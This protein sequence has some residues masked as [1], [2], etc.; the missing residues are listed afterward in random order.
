LQQSIRLIGCEQ[1]SDL[2]SYVRDRE[3]AAVLAENTNRMG[4]EA[5]ALISASWAG[6]P[7]PAQVVVPPL[8]ITKDNV[9]TAEA[10]LYKHY[11]R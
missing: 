5:V 9:N 1:V 11:T 2:I 8:V 3:I 6:Q 4:L 7:M 10:N